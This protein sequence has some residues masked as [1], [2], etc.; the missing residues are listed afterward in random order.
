MTEPIKSVRQAKRVR[1]KARR[2]KN[3]EACDAELENLPQTWRRDF[4]AALAE[5]SNV[6]RACAAVRVCSRTVYDL[7]RRDPSFAERWAE[8]LCEG[9]DNLEMEMLFY[10]RSG[11]S[12]DAGAPKFNFPAAVRM[13]LAHREA[14][15]RE[16]GR[17]AEV[18]AAEI[19]ASIDRKVQQMRE[20]IV[21][22]RVPDET[23]TGETGN[24]DETGNDD[25]AG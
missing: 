18:D 5:T 14:V 20:R 6:S 21:A 10:L 23:P 25:D 15:S 17:R 11:D 2:A 8:A 4:L 7:R 9:Y 12:P 24:G 22:R 3:P 16:K 19:R 13:L 1:H